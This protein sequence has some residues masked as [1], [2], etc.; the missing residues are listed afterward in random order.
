MVREFEETA[1]QN[2]VVVF[3]PW[4]ARP[5]PIGSDADLEEAISLAAS[6][7]N[8]WCN[9]RQDQIILVIGADSTSVVSGYTC[10]ATLVQLLRSLAIVE[11]QSVVT[12][13]GVFKALAS[14]SIQDAAILVI[15]SRKSSP[16]ATALA[17]S[18]RRLVVS[19]SPAT[20][21]DFYDPTG[22]KSKPELAHSK[23]TPVSR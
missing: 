18:W 14:R 6:V 9:Q 20:A 7:C 2:L 8:E 23:L 1:G 16:V 3:D 11:G 15:G 12:A 5:G 19:L 10:R 17:T 13:H 22:T 4:S 21:R